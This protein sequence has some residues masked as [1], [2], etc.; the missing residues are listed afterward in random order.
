MGLSGVDVA[1]HSSL[2][3]FGHIEGGAGTVVKAMTGICGTVLMPTFCNIGRCNPPHGDHPI[4]N[5][6]DYKAYRPDESKLVYFNPEKFDKTSSIEREMGRISQAFL[7]LERT[8]RSK[9]PSV[10]WAANGLK[11]GYY[12]EG[13]VADDPNLPLKKLYRNNG[14][15]LLLGVD[16]RTCTAIH[17]AEEMLGRRPFI[18]WVMYNDGIRHR[19]REYGCSN[20]FNK[21]SEHVEDIAEVSRIGQSTARKYPIRPLVDRA[22]EI[23]RKYPEITLCDSESYCRCQ[24]AVKGGPLE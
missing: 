21:I 12:T 16:L 4:Q 18:R 5:G 14:Y 3:S 24:D 1:V 13:H 20:G 11:A 15:I 9:H 23:I 6:W 2:S 7:R 19:V 8:V 10:S 17:L 22:A